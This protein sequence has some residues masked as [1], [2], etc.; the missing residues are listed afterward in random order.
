MAT[1]IS[2]WFRYVLVAT[3]IM[4]LGGSF[5]FAPPI[6]NHYDMLGFPQNTHPLYLWIISI[7]ILIFGVGYLWLAF[8][9]KSEPLFI[10]V[11]AAAKLVFAVLFFAF[12]LVGDLPLITALPG[13][14]DLLFAIAFI[15][16]LRQERKPNY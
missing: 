7:W 14:S 8:T 16:W 13:S 2:T 5:I 12:Y 11:A 3:A 9:A 1:P 6:L 15:Y 10:A 4:N